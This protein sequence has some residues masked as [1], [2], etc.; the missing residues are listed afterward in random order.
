[1]NQEPNIEMQKKGAIEVKNNFENI[2]EIKITD[3]HE[4]AP[5]VKQIGF[6]VI[7]N[8]GKIIKGNSWT[9]GDSGYY[10]ENGFKCLSFDGRFLS[11]K[12]DFINYDLK[13]QR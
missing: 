4:G 5:G 6:D 8:N 9:I 11:L 10:I 7:E 1:M 2:K 13:N 3:L 12:S